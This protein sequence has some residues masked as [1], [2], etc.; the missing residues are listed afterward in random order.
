MTAKEKKKTY[1]LEINDKTHKE[2]TF[3][4]FIRQ[5]CAL[6]CLFKFLLLS[7]KSESP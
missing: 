5:A 4:Q 6:L 2:D 1:I 3:P 7:I